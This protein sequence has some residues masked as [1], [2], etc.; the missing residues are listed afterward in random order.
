MNSDVGHGNVIASCFVLHNFALTYERNTLEEMTT[1]VAGEHD[2]SMQDEMVQ[3]DSGFAGGFELVH[4]EEDAEEELLEGQTKRN[5][6]VRLSVGSV[7][8]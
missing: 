5:E 4:V 8:I 3:H 1:V 7:T 6:V 2:N